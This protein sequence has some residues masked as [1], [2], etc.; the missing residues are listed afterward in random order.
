[1]ADFSILSRYK[2]NAP[3]IESMEDH[4]FYPIDSQ[5]I[6]EAEKNLGFNLPM[7]LKEFYQT[8]GY[9]FFWQKSG[10]DR[11]RLLSPLQVAQITLKEDFYEFDPDLELYDDLYNGDKLL[12]IE[13]NEGVYLGIDRVDQEG[14]NA[15]YYMQNK[16]ANSLEEFVQAFAGNPSLISDLS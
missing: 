2:V 6:S 7:E 9:G 3:Q 13:V 5:Q 12:F 16:I 10:T 4:V 14:K 8:I 11:N 15:V 1:M